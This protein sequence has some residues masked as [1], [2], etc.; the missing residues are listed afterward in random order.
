MP[1]VSIPGDSSLTEKL[2][3]EILQSGGGGGGG[4]TNYA[5]ETGGILDTIEFDLRNIESTANQIEAYTK[6]LPKIF[7]ENNGVSFLNAGTS[8]AQ[9][10]VI[11]AN[12]DLS[13][14]FTS[15]SSVRLKNILLAISV[16]S[17]TNAYQVIFHNTN[18]AGFAL[19]SVVAAGFF[20]GSA[21]FNKILA[22]VE[23]GSLIEFGGGSIKS[24]DCDKIMKTDSGALFMTIIASGAGGYTANTNFLAKVFFEDYI[25]NQF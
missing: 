7:K 25:H 20:S 17:A 15:T 5:L 1:I 11:M 22:I 9:G 4:I 12:V 14:L 13:G 18:I 16:H 8:Y 10:T 2:L 3:F 6:Y 19:G 23:S 24:I 21:N